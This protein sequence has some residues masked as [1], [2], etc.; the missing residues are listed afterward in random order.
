MN[1]YLIASESYKIIDEKVK[2]LIKDKLNVI[3]YDL[4]LN[5][6]IDVINEANY[7]S[8]FGDEKYIVVKATNLFKSNKDEVINE[9]EIKALEEYFK[10]PNPLCTIIFTSL[11]M[12]DKRKKVYKKILE[13][14]KVD[15]TVTLNKKEMVYSCI[16]ILRKKGFDLSYETANYIVENSFVNY[17]IMLNEIDKITMLLKPNKIETEDINKIVSTSVNSNIFGFMSAIINK[18]IKKASIE[19]KYFEVLKIEPSMV[20]VLL[21]KEFEILYLLQSEISVN[22]IQRLFRKEDWQMNNYVSYKNKYTL[23]DIK[24]IIVKLNDYDY[25][26]K[27]GLIDRSVIINLLIIDLCEN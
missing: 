27:T 6:L 17:D 4:R 9:Q 11:Q 2:L 7:Y 14:G 12:P 15:I 25:K 8:L 26:L 18:D 16:D 22:N 23:N 10:N 13:L 24:K 20:I 21:A 19:S 3:Y 1:V 5:K